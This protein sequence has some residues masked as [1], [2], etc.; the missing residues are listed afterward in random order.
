MVK[1]RRTVAEDEDPH[2]AVLFRV[3]TFMIRRAHQIATAVFMQACRELDLTPSQY[4]ALF[5]LRHGGAFS[6]N[7]LGRVVALDRCTTSIVVR[8]LTERELIRRTA[9]ENDQRKVVLRL[10]DAGRL[11][12]A[13]AERISG[14]ASREMLGVLSESQA[15]TFVDLLERFTRAH[16][17]S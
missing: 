9:D 6:Q 14:R 2:S 3:P 8:T 13:R 17:G 16:A 1:E 12:L 11:L 4:A 7:R 15:Q 5:A 10:T